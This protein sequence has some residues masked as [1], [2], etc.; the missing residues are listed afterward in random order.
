M[1][2]STTWLLGGFTTISA[3]VTIV[4]R[5]V[6][7][8]QSGRI[9]VLEETINALKNQVSSYEGQLNMLLKLIQEKD[10]MIDDERRES[11]ALRELNKQLTEKVVVL[12]GRVNYLE[13]LSNIQ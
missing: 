11:A 7:E 3:I 12:E 8:S 10:A 6:Q 2:N 9:K 5:T 1:D 13:S 4:V